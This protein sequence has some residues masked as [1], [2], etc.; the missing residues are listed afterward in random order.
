MSEQSRICAGAA[1]GALVGA[2]ATYL[3]YT[4][5]GRS[6]RDRLEPA[7]DDLMRDFDKLR[8]TIEKLGGMANDGL[9]VL[10]EFQNARG[11]QPF[12]GSGAAH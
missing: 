3:F 11:Q 7:V 10:H 8:G 2:V 1:I 5:G 12:S 6:V 4:E 9:R